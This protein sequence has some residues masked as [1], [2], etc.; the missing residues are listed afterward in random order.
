MS[1]EILSVLEY[2][3]KEKGIG[4]EDMI[5]TI[6]AAIHNAASKGVN[7]GQELKVEINPKTGSLQAWAVLHVVDSVSDP[8]MEI[9]IEKA[10]QYDANAEV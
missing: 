8:V 9:H 1:N 2:M 7:A 3:E 10:R 6:V 5:S 4:R